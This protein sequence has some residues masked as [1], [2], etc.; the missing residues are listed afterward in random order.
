MLCN[1]LTHKI[2]HRVLHMY[3]VKCICLGNTSYSYFTQGIKQVLLKV[4]QAWSTWLVS[5][6]RLSNIMFISNW[7][8]KWYCAVALI[9]TLLLGRYSELIYDNFQWNFGWTAQI[10]SFFSLLSVGKAL[11]S[12]LDCEETERNKQRESMPGQWVLHCM[13]HS[14]IQ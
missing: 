14:G 11:H 2:R 7:N 3:L 9:L 4:E 5:F 1:N 13:L 10:N 6:F 12:S 8:I